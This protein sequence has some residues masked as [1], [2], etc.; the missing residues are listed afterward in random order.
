MHPDKLKKRGYNQA[1]EI[2]KGMNQVIKP[3]R[4]VRLLECHQKK[5]SQTTQS[6][7]ERWS[8]L[9]GVFRVNQEELTNKPRH[10]ILVDDVLTTG[11]TM[12]TCANELFRTVQPKTLS[13]A[14][15][16]IAI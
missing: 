4:V 5:R 2:A 8:D 1:E 11:A 9:E 13:L 7:S 14:T 15:I 6:K 3:A 16:A 12:Q 10:L